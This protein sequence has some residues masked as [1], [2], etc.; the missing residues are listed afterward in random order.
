[1]GS[2]EGEPPTRER[3][4][5][6]TR[7]LSHTLQTRVADG[8]HVLRPCAEALTGAHVLRHRLRGTASLCTLKPRV[9]AQRPSYLRLR[10]PPFSAPSFIFTF[11]HPFFITGGAA[12]TGGASTA[13]LPANH[14]LAASLLAEPPCAVSKWAASVWI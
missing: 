4:P 13:S 6:V 14:H 11:F 8:F 10:A 1:M 7:P 5:G 12:C 2:H 9:S 3:M